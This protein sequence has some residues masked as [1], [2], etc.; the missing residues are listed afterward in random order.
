VAP[1]KVKECK[2]WM[3]EALS[4]SLPRTK[5]L[6]VLVGAPGIGKSTMVRVLAR[7]LDLEVHS[8]RDSFAQKIRGQGEID[9]LMSVERSSGLDSF[10][11]FLTKCGKGFSCLPLTSQKSN[12]RRSI[13]LLED[14]PTLH[15]NAT[16]ARFRDIM[17][18][19]LRGSQ[20]PII[21]IFSDVSEGRHKPAD[22][23]MII[24]RDDLYS[25]ASL[26]CQ[27]H[28]V[29][30]TK[31]KRIV[32]KIARER[33]FTVPPGLIEE[34]HLQTGGDLR[35]ALMTL[36][37][38]STG[39]KT[40]HSEAKGGCNK[41]DAKLSTFHA[42]GR[43]L[44]SKREVDEFGRSRLAFDPEGI[45]ERSDLGVG[46]SLRFLEYHSVDFFTD[47]EDIAN[48]YCLF[49]DAAMLLDSAGLDKK[50]LSHRCAS[51]VAGVRII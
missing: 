23:E 32:Q 48:A 39:L 49:S 17:T 25:S 44:Y 7:E 34:L 37:F 29:T 8:W 1:K 14:L 5:R 21:L 24:D 50:S 20:V 27:I 51:S 42:L 2:R 35:S 18:R 15:D 22:L 13:I 43:L 36:Q 38:L 12:V 26:I 3:V 19:S 10:E 16:A 4:A 33:N 40:L 28:P 30:K 6:L 45:L 9:Q 47:T 11:E 46:G 31:T 41:R